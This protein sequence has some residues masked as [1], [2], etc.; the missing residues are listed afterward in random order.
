MPF[1]PR[2]IAM[3]AFTV[4]PQKTPPP[5][6]PEEAPRRRWR[7]WAALALLLLGV[8]GLAW[9]VR[10]DPHLSRA[11]ALQKELFSPAAKGLSP[12]ERKARFAEYREHVKHLTDDQKWQLAAP[13]REKQQAELDRYFALAPRDRIKYLDEKIDRSEKMRK[14]W[15]KKAAQSKA[16]RPKGG[17]AFAAGSPKGGGPKGGGRG[18]ALSAEEKEKRRKQFLDRTTP[19]ERAKMDRFRKDM[20]DRRK[21]RGLPTRT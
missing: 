7:R 17:P 5:A 8:G 14:E 10:P 18:P 20:T 6:Q 13:M 11:Q 15:E 21:Q 2:R 3:H 1:D 9:A 16:A 19:E 12:E 4:H